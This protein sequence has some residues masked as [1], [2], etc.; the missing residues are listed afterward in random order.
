MGFGD[1]V[2]AMSM[3][4]EARFRSAPAES[5]FHSFPSSIEYAVPSAAVASLDSEALG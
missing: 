2:G 1:A 5:T 3:S 4:S